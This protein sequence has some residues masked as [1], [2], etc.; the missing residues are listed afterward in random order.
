MNVTT[1]GLTQI[2]A[3]N[4]FYQDGVHRLIIGI[5]I[6]FVFNIF[7]IFSIIYI[8]THPPAPVYFPTS[9]NGRITPIYPLDQPNPGDSVVLQ[10]TNLAA[11]A[12]FS[13]N[14]VNYRSE[15][16]AASEFFTADGWTSFLKSIK[17]SNN[18]LAVVTKKLVVSGQATRTPEILQKGILNGRYSWRIKIPMI[19]TYQSS[20]QY[21]TQNVDVILLVTR[22]STLNN[23]QGIGID[24]FVTS[25]VDTTQGGA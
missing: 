25:T 14:F 16:E 15:L 23:P 24:Q 12:A 6:S 7:S 11:I 1:D 20:E 19:I 2:V 18:L 5:I 21:T 3:R 22:I 8:Y 13:Y 9:A 4:Q 17:D 10:W